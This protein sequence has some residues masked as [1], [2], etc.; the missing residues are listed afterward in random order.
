MNSVITYIFGNGEL[1]RDPVVITPGVQYYVITD[2]AD[3]KSHVWNPIVVPRIKSLTVRDQVAAVKFNPFIIQSSKYLIIDS[4][5]QIIS[6]L[7]PIF[8]VID[9]NTMCVKKHPKKVDIGT[10]ISRWRAHRDMS[11]VHE[12]NIKQFLLNSN[13]DYSKF[14]IYEGCFIGI[15]RSYLHMKLFLSTLYHL[16]LMRDTS[17]WFPSNQIVLSYFENMFLPDI[18]LMPVNTREY[19]IRYQHNTWKEVRE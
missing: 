11:Q 1:L 17:R 7:R 3:I 13:P 8:D 19:A 2:N 9:Q 4:S 12:K 6:N 5:H 10:E 16:Y 15:S 14:P 18:K